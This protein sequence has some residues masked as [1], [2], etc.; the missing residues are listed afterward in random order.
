MRSRNRII[1]P[2]RQEAT[3]AGGFK[4]RPTPRGL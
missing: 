1:T 2:G 4:R 3:A